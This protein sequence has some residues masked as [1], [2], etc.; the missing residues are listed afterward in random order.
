MIRRISVKFSKVVGFVV[1]LITMWSWTLTQNMQEVDFNYSCQEMTFSDQIDQWP[2]SKNWHKNMTEIGRLKIQHYELSINLS[3]RQNVATNLYYQAPKAYQTPYVHKKQNIG[4][5]GI[6]MLATRHSFKMAY[7]N[8]ITLRSFSEIAIEIFHYDELRFAQEIVFSNMVNVNVVNLKDLVFVSQRIQYIDNTRNYQ[9]KSAALLA[10]QFEDIL[11]LDTDNLPVK[12]PKPFFDIPEY[13]QFGLILWPDIWKTDP[14]NPIFG[15]FDIECRNQWETEA[16]QMLI[17]K[18]VHMKTLLMSYYIMQDRVFWF[19]FL[20]G[21]K[22]VMRYAAKVVGLPYKIVPWFPSIVGYMDRFKGDHFFCGLVMLQNGF[23]GT[24]MFFHANQVKYRG[25]VDKDLFQKTQVYRYG[26][27]NLAF[28][29]V[30]TT[31][32]NGFGCTALSERSQHEY[33]RLDV[34]ETSSL[35][36]DFVDRWIALRDELMQSWE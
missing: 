12:D 4:K 28:M 27:N 26:H 7:A 6:V 24:P 17:N 15:I 9:L 10:S 1:L 31:S 33:T 19:D 11:F 14:K 21:D 2:I 34:K 30:L 3:Y 32:S 16:G 35:L 18:K 29:P 36:G 13:K 22:D 20:F 8:I 25:H 23:D 5:Q